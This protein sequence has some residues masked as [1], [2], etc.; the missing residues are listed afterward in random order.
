MVPFVFL[1][2]DYLGVFG[3]R[4][5][6]GAFALTTLSEGAFG[7]AALGALAL[8]GALVTLAGL[9]SSLATG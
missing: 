9:A 8:A 6:R 1:S 5:L 7:L 2:M 4:G 3:A